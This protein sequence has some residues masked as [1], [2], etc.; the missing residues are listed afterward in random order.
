MPVIN[1]ERAGAKRSCPYREY[2]FIGFFIAVNSI[3][4]L[5]FS[6]EPLRLS[7]RDRFMPDFL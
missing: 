7:N 2:K 1:K 4:A 6:R 5:D 3:I